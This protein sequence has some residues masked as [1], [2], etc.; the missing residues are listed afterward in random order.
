MSTTEIKEKIVT[1]GNYFNS[2]FAPISLDTKLTPST[3]K[4]PQ[5]IETETKVINSSK[6]NWMHQWYPIHAV[7]TIDK[8]NP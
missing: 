5:N 8:R 2:T 3:K 7:D 4:A 6:N 1:V